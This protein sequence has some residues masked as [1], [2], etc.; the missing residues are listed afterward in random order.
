LGF[1]LV[2][3]HIDREAR[4]CFVEAEKLD[5]RNPR[6]P[7]LQAMLLSH[8]DSEQA[9]RKLERTIDLCPGDEDAPR[10]R[11]GE[12]LLALG[13]LTSAD[14]QFR[15]VLSRDGANARA[16]RIGSRR[17]SARKAR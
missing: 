4:I 11:L 14:E 9:I 10:L 12:S 3:H 16:P 6:W 15:K 1:V 17:L 13:R 8:E 5:S 7:Y 2:A